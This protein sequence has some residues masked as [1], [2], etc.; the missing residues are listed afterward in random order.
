M[1]NETCGF[2]GRAGSEKEF[3]RCLACGGARCDCCPPVC[4]E[5]AIQEYVEGWREGQ[6][7]AELE[8]LAGL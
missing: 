4:C 8:R 2:C 6:E 1:E 3:A 7:V 5:A